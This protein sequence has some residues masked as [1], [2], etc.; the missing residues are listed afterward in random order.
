LKSK[1]LEYLEYASKLAE[2]GVG[3]VS[4]NPVVGSVLVRD[5]KVISEDWHRKAGEGHAERNLLESFK[6]KIQEDDL[7]V[8]TLEPCCHQ[9]K[10]PPCTEIILKSGVKKVLVG[11]LDP[12]PQVA[13][14]G[15]ALLRKAGVEVLDLE[16]EYEKVQG[17]RGKVQEEPSPLPPTP[18]KG[19]QPFPLLAQL[20][21]QNR[22]FFTWVKEHRPWVA[23]KIAQTLDGRVVPERGKQYW[24]T[25]EESRQH[26]HGERAKYDAIL[27]GLGTV[28]AD[29]PTLDL[30]LAIPN[31]QI[32]MAKRKDPQVIILDAA[33]TLP[34]DKKVIRK[35]TIIFS[36]RQFRRREK[37]KAELEELGVKVL[38]VDTTPEGLLNLRQVLDEL[39]AREITSL[40]V[41]GGAGVWSSF[42]RENL[43]NEVMMYFA[44]QFLGAGVPS[45]EELD[46]SE[47]KKVQF[48]ETQILGEDVFWR[49]SFE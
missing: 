39:A 31:D 46:F 4:P 47:G 1:Y 21:W 13:G 25:G 7:L 37:R 9:G 5:G 32:P 28:L 26:V 45:L 49:G 43:V 30:R 8:I 11:L 20:R 14:K 38:E 22:F 15:I 17:P 6:G 10:T 42:L 35:G 16:E 18:L 44:P 40:Y 24:L 23:L 19:E 41:E 36:G 27:V 34:L 29:N 12:N 48:K 2:N 3:F 33:L